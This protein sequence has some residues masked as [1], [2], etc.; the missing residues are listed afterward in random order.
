MKRGG[1]VV[2]AP[3]VVVALVAVAL[4]VQ[5]HHHSL[6]TGEADV[7]VDGTAVVALAGGGNE[8]ITDRARLH[9]GDVLDVQQGVARITTNDA[10]YQA[11]SS[12]DSG[13]AAT[14]SADT[15]LKIGSE[16][17]LLAGELLVED[18]SGA[19]VQSAGTAVTVGSD[20][21]DGA[22][23]LS[24]TLSLGV[25]VYRGNAQINSAGSR[26]TVSRLRSVEVVSLGQLPVDLLPVSVTATDPWDREFLSDAIQI[27]GDLDPLTVAFD[28]ASGGAD[29][30]PASLDSAH[31]PATASPALQQLISSARD[32][33]PNLE[34]S[35][36]IVGALIATLAKGD[37]FASHWNAVFAFHHEGASWGLVAM[38]QNVE[39]QALISR[40]ASAIDNQGSLS[41]GQVTTAAPPVTQPVLTGPPPT[42]P[43]ATTATQPSLATS[44]PTTRPAPPTTQP[45]TGLTLP[46]VPQLISPGTSGTTPLQGVVDGATTLLSGLLNA[47][48]GP[49]G[50][51]H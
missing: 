41:F 12:F 19:T 32:I 27:N 40:V 10:K 38:D 13:S 45:Q 23:R 39:R 14:R 51:L 26:L 18:S 46:I 47:L 3:I 31:L 15:R 29:I 35:G 44:T 9:A 36:A 11:R 24:R 28:K 48:V 20:G 50:L 30:T 5:G 22:A 7:V 37:S 4:V 8:T 2:L 42:A 34:L 1:V 21:A 49:N 33:D 16:P 6:G 17:E 43:P 25:S